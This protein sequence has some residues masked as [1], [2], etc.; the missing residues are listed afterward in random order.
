MH[1]LPTQAASQRGGIGFKLLF[2]LALFGA[3]VALAWMCLLPEAVARLVRAR[4]GFGIEIQSLYA[5]PF[6][7]DL[8]IHGLVVTNPPS[9]PRKDFVEL[10][11]FRAR[12]RLFSLFSRRP[13]IDDAVIDVALVC[14]VKDAHGLI[15]T[16]VFQA[17]LLG[18]AAG[19]PPGTKPEEREFLI[20]R[21]QVRLDRLVIADYSRR[22]PDVREFNLNFNHAYENVTSARQLAVPLGDILSPVAGAIGGIL[23]E[24]GQALRTAGAAVEETGRKTGE[25]VKGFFDA[26]EKTLKR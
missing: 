23:P 25:A 10:R 6:T 3:G 19:P 17:G 8:E 15:N 24:A 4:T 5:N 1:T 22:R 7:A 21:L 14:L 26:L 11:E 13:V 9:F 16:R 2:F 20:K 18:P 12:A